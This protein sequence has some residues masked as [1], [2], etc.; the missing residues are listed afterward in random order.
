MAR[1][2]IIG[3]GVVGLASA[4]ALADQRWSVTVID[5]DP[6]RQA[7][8]WGNA[9]HI[10]I[11]QGA[12]L[13]S[14][15]ALRSAPR[16]LF[17]RGGALALPPRQIGRWLPFGLRLARA[18]APR[19]FEAGQAALA[20][21]LAG[22]MPAWH[23]LAAGLDAPDLVREHGHIVAWESA[24][25]AA[26]G[27]R[28]WAAAPI[29]TARFRAFDAAE[30]AAL[31][32]LAPAGCADAIRFTNTG[33][34]RDLAALADALTARL[35]ARGGRIVPG[36]ATLRRVS[37]G[38]AEAVLEDG[39]TLRADLILVAAGVRAPALLAPFGHRA[40]IIAERGYH[41][42]ADAASWPDDLPPIVFEDRAMIVTR[43]AGCVQA[44]SFVELS[45]ADAPADPAKWARLEA[46]VAALGLP[47]R[48]PF[49]RWMGSRPTLPDY[50]PA[51]GRSRRAPN[52]LYAFGHQ[53]L[54]LT[55]APITGEIVAALAA[56]TAPPVPLAPFDIARFEKDSA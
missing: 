1:A 11:E 54:G 49:T 46:H 6:A 44:A 19:R 12:P 9:G 41:I 29:G 8:S 43:Y 38:A 50:L 52:L 30:R 56:G 10:A 42:R 34:I 13:A 39:A 20:P 22:A 45:D 14:R 51:I 36:R 27:R 7:A 4:V 37:G 35:A 25:S 40:P 15:A 26:A 32:R 3:G 28:A 2:V 33:Q 17:S 24:A 31:A 47:L 23:R 48:P 5:A 55:L 18:A 16:R 53:H 21:L